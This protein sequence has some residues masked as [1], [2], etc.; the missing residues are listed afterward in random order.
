MLCL[1]GSLLIAHHLRGAR[2]ALLGEGSRV[3]VARHLGR[4]VERQLLGLNLL[5]KIGRQR[6]AHRDCELL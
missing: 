6:D 4:R 5:I 1:R 3:P 2:S